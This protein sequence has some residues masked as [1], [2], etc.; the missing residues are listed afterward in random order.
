[1]ADKTEHVFRW[2]AGAGVSDL[3]VLGG[4]TVYASGASDD[5]LVVFGRADLPKSNLHEP[6]PFYWTPY[7]GLRYV[8]ELGPDWRVSPVGLS[9]DGSKLLL[10][11]YCLTTSSQLQWIFFKAFIM[12]L[13]TER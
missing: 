4:A 5:G 12:D 1:M 8:C 10:N 13:Q 7:S 11:V 3:G 9:R 2:K 6:V